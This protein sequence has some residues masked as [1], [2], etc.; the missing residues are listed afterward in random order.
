MERLVGVSG[1]GSTTVQWTWKHHHIRRLRQASK[2]GRIASK[3]FGVGKYYVTSQTRLILL[4]YETFELTE[5]L[6]F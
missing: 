3:R 4:E 2:Q 6:P 5:R 1:H